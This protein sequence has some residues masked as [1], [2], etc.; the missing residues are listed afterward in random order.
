MVSEAAALILRPLAKGDAPGSRAMHS[1]VLMRRD[2]ENGND[3]RRRTEMRLCAALIAVARMHLADHVDDLPEAAAA[4]SLRKSQTG[5]VGYMRWRSCRLSI[6]DARRCRSAIASDSSAPSS[7]V[8][9]HEA[10]AI[11]GLTTQVVIEAWRREYNE[12]RP[13]KVLGGLMPAAH[14]KQLARKLLQ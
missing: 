3:R 8:W 12:E 7:Q 10:V 4:R 9:S 14:A 6:A 1:D 2:I 5:S 11:V 13:K